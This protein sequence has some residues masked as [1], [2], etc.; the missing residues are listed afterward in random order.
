MR[1]VTVTLSR[2]TALKALGVKLA[3][4]D[5]GTGYSSLAYLRQFP[6][7][8]LKIDQALYRRSDSPEAGRAGSNA[9]PARKGAR[10][11][12]DCRG[13]RDR[14]SARTPACRERRHW[15]GVLV[16]SAA[17]R[18]GSRNIPDGVQLELVGA[19]RW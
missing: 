9:R 1:D 6:I 10:S 5:F 17:R 2:L 3:V 8:I 16:L 18:V 19:R 11:H 14:R 13:Y 15:A 4:D 7:D 12:D